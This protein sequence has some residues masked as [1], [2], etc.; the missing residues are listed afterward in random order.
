[1]SHPSK[2]RLYTLMILI[3]MALSFEKGKKTAF[4]SR[5]ARLKNIGIEI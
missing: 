3:K 5:Q 1:M 2:I 4:F